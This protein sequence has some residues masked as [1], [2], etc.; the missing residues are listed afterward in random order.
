[1]K[2]SSASLVFAAALFLPVLAIVEPAPAQPV[3]PYHAVAEWPKIPP[4][5]QMGAGMGIS[6]DAGGRIWAYNRGSHSLIQLNANGEVLEAWKDGTVV[7]HSKAAHG[8]RI[9]PDGGLWLVGREAQTIW[10]YAP[11][12]RVELVIGSFGGKAGDNDAFYAF[13]RPT[14][15]AVDSRGDVYVGDGYQNS[16]VVKYSPEG[17]YLLH[18]GKPGGGD[19]QFKL[20][21]D[22]AVDAQDFIYVADRGNERVQVFTPAGGFLAKWEGI[23]VPWGLAYDR[24][25]NVMWMCDGDNG[26]ISKLN[27]DGE[28]LGVLGENGKGPGQ[29]D[30]IHGITVDEAGNLYVC[31][32][33][34]ARLQKLAPN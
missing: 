26:R 3:L 10:K 4:E 19:G 27:L 34:N 15:I 32:T 16:R 21:H 2:L 9:A 25:R 29:F 22:V 14:G 12:G 8:L 18:W 5:I 7:L 6:V 20:V 13:N 17:E 33:R 24:W 31:E 30:Q 23:G 28:V 11:G 1:M